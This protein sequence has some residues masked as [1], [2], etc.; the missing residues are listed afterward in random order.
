[1]KELDNKHI[2]LDTKFSK[3]N[4]AEIQI[5]YNKNKTFADVMKEYN[6]TTYAVSTAIK[7]GLL[8]TRTRQET[9]NIRGTR[10]KFSKEQLSAYAKQRNLGG[11]RANAGKSKKFKA[12]DTFG[13]EVTLQSTYELRMSQLL[14][15]LNIKWVRPKALKYNNKNYFADFYLT[16]Y[17]VYLDTKNDYLARLDVGKI[18]QVITENNVR[19]YIITNKQITKEYVYSLIT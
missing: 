8:K 19:L 12:K 6:L 11:Y 7:R 10:Y 9:L 18:Q 14:N 17:N 5:F 3:L 16:E 2:S 1:M 15:E 13:K 4:W